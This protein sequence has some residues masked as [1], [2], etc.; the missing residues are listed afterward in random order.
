MLRNRVKLFLSNKVNLDFSID[1]VTASA[2]QK[3]RKGALF[4]DLIQNLDMINN[5]REKNKH[6]FINLKK[7]THVSLSNMNPG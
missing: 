3:I 4:R 5:Y 2:Y 1:G 6:N 7:I